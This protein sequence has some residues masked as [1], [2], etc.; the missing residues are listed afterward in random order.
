MFWAHKEPVYF[1]E[2]AKEYL[3]NLKFQN[4]RIRANQVKKWS[5][6][7][8]EDMIETYTKAVGDLT[9]GV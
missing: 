9:K 7:E 1:V 3:G 4:L 8:L 6:A 5:I 2:F